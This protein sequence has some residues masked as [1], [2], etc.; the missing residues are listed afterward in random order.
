[1]KKYLIHS[2]LFTAFVFLTT[3]TYGLDK[4]PGGEG[5]ITVKAGVGDFGNRCFKP[6]SGTI[7][8]VC[9]DYTISWK[10]WSL[11]GEPVG[12]YHLAWKLT[13]I[14]LMDPQR[15]SASRYTPANMPI[16][17]KK[18]AAAIELYIDAVAEVTLDGECKVSYNFLSKSPENVCG[19]YALHHFN[20][21]VA[22][23]AGAGGSMNVPDGMSWDKLLFLSQ[24]GSSVCLP[25][26]KR[27]HL[28][29]DEAKAKFKQ[30]VKL[31]NLKICPGSGV[32]ELSSLERAIAK[33]CAKPGAD[34]SNSFCPKQKKDEKNKESDK[35]GNQGKSAGNTQSGLMEE[36][37]DGPSS[38]SGEDNRT[39]E[40]LLDEDAE[41]PQVERKLAQL[42]AAYRH[43]AEKACRITMHQIDSCYAKSSCKRPAE[44]PSVDQCSSIPAYPSKP[45]AALVLT[46]SPEPGDVCYYVDAECRAE[47]ARKAAREREESRR[48]AEELSEKQDEWNSRYQSLTQACN[49]LKEEREVFGSCQKKYGATC[50]PDG[51]G[52]QSACVEQ[53][54]SASGPSE[55]DARNQLKQ[56]WNAKAAAPDRA[57]ASNKSPQPVTNFL[58]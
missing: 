41:R 23:R 58:D 38:N 14:E 30:G 24:S 54:M 8:E 39:I 28:N 25:E 12:D 36:L 52:G 10:L 34:R 2:L 29:A 1:M 51:F 13:S 20:T 19:W 6:S 44:S 50:N 5:K 17:L 56:E 4:K 3:P 55:K 27:A 33:L 32:F 40:D 47:R 35:Q 22:V 57:P 31:G 11:M 21:G 49:K 15:K 18:A 16:A 48:E 7:R 43:K 42:R 46:R 37:L 26:K 45:R 53:R 9:A